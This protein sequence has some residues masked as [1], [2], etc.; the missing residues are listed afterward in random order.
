MTE[1]WQ[2]ADGGGEEGEGLTAEGLEG[3]FWSEDVL[4]FDSSFI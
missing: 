4:N 3:T 2:V 1:V